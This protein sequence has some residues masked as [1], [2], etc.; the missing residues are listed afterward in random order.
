M[1][2][3]TI[4]QAMQTLGIGRTKLYQLLNDGSLRA[5]KLG[6]KTLILKDS[7]DDYVASLPSYKPKL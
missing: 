3:L 7:L 6:S 5:F 4:N 2:N 1:L